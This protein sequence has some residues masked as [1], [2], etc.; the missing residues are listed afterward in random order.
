MVI[1]LIG[2]IGA[3]GS[4]LFTR[5]SSF[6]GFTARDQLVAVS[7]LAQKRA[8]ALV[9]DTAAKTNPVILTF[10]QTADLWQIDLRQ[11]VTENGVSSTTNFRQRTAERA[12]ASVAINGV[13]LANGG[14]QIITFNSDAETGNNTQFVFSGDSTHSLCISSTG[15]AYVGTCQL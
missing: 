13:T 8:L 14:S 5:T 7:L 12:S 15:F 3:V 6:S 4:S 1:L 11:V 10:S 9:D 2:I